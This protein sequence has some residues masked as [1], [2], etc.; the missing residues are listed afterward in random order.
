MTRSSLLAKLLLGVALGATT[1][2]AARVSTAESS[3][4]VNVVIHDT[5]PQHR[6]LAIEWN[7]LALFLQRFSVDFVV[8]PGDHHA[9]V[10]SPFYTWASTN[11]YATA[12]DG[13][14]NPL[15]DAKGSPYTLNVLPQTFRG[16]GGELGYR[17]YVDEGGP[18]GFFVGPS[19]I[20][21]GMRAT[22]GNGSETSYLD[23]GGALDIGYEAVIADAI[24]FTVGGG[25]QYAVPTRSIPP[26]QWPATVYAN[27][28][29]QPRLL[30]SLGYAF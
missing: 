15:V 8:A 25:A 18:R 16:F 17:Y 27:A 10:V 20:L 11:P 22:A 29:V 19:L 13:N 1:T 26:Q 5:A 3:Q 12:I 2:T 7:P 9:L 14:G 23:I 30:L 24:V 4:P 28:R 6:A 21:A